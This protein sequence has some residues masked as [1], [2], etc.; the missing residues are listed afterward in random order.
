M[1][2]SK[3][4]RMQRHAG[5]A[6]PYAMSAVDLLEQIEAETELIEKKR[7]ERKYLKKLEKQLKDQFKD[8]L[9][10]LTTSQGKI[11]IDM[12]ERETEEPFYETLK[13]LKNPVTAFF[14]QK[15]GKRFGYDLKTKYDPEQ[16]WMLEKI[17]LELE[18]KAL[19]EKVLE[20]TDSE[21]ET[22]TE[23]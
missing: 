23:N 15:I 13:G 16:D 3:Y 5:I 10:N 11:L 6:Y 7:H 18:A 12:I 14:F 17:I 4:R 1:D 9:T 20:G 22:E 19:E 8:E 21:T 2:M